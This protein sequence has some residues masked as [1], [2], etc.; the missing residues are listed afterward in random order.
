MRWDRTRY[1]QL[2][3][4]G[5]GFQLA[6]FSQLLYEPVVKW[7]LGIFG[8][9]TVAGHFEMANRAVFQARSLIVSIYQA[10]VPFLASRI[11]SGSYGAGDVRSAYIRSL[12]ILLLILPSYFSLIIAAFPTLFTFWLGEFSADFLLMATICLIGW[13]FNVIAVPA[14]MFTLANGQ[15]RIVAYSQALIGGLN[16]ILA[17]LGGYYFGGIGV[18]VGAMVALS[19]GSLLVLTALHREHSVTFRQASPE[20]SALMSYSLALSGSLGAYTIRASV[21]LIFVHGIFTCW[22]MWRHPI[23]RSIWARMKPF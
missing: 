17:S 22:F 5:G 19:V 8:G 9:L 10:L 7:L 15:I 1:K 23:L 4:Y 14:Y 20:L 21:L 2:L 12:G 11:G 13:A 16:I 6:A 18:V 3:R